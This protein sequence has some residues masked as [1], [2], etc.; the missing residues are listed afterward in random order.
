MSTLCWIAFNVVVKSTPAWHH[1][2]VNRCGLNLEQRRHLF[3][4][5]QSSLLVDFHFGSILCSHNSRECHESLSD[6]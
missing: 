2:G 6:M 1:P 4:R 3:A 5:I